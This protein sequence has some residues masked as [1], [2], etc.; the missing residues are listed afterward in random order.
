MSYKLIAL[1][2]DGTLTNSKKEITDRTRDA[3]LNIQE[4]GVQVVLASG[5]PTPGMIHYADYLQLDRYGSFVLSFNG[6]KMTNW[7]TKEIVYSKTLPLEFLPDLYETAVS[8]HVGIITYR[9]ETGIAGTTP[10]EYMLLEMRLNGMQCKY[11]ENFT[12]YVNFPINKCIMTGK[13][14]ELKPVAELLQKKYE[15]RLSIYF[16]EPYFLEIMPQNVDKA[17]ALLS[18]LEMQGLRPD[19]MICCG[20]GFN[21][22]SMIEAAGLGVAMA[23]APTPVKAAADYITSSNDKDGIVEVIHKFICSM[24]TP[25]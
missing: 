2:I 11:V 16:S 12:D 10:D 20:D 22:I 3:L 25:A 15:G 21:D 23:N 19:E 13:H 1:D 24:A 18:L 6:A 4:R 8:H 5:R 9:D 17:Q 14:E 7:K